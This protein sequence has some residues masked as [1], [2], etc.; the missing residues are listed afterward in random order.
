MNLFGQSLLAARRLVE[1]GCR[2]A[3]VFW[4][5]VGDATAGWDTHFHHYSRL[6]E[7][8]L[9]GFDAAFATLILDLE[10]RGL[11]EETLVLVLSEH[12]RTPRLTNRPGAGREHW[13]AAYCGAAAGGG[14]A[15]GHVVGR[16]DSIA[17]HVA[18]NPLSPK[19]ILATALHLLG[20]NPHTMV[21]DRLNRPVPVAGEGV[22]RRE[23]L[24]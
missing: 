9:P 5:A 1:S 11:L 21:T 4:D 17:A 10:T 8:L 7:F 20:I 22:V 13:S 14:I 23:L 24:A 16:T 15:R 3:T 18:D 12:G 2:C 6:R 19:D